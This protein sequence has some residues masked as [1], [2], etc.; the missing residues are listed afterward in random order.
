M[1]AKVLDL[2]HG[3]WCT[4]ETIDPIHRQYRSVS[5]SVGP[6]PGQSANQ[7]R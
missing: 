2:I 5:R 6:G 3:S 7:R 4:T 1:F